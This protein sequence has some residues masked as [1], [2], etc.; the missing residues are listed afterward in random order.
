MSRQITATLGFSLVVAGLPALALALEW[1]AL[2]ADALPVPMWAL[3]CGGAALVFA[4]SS[5][6]LPE[7]FPRPRGFLCALSVSALAA[8]FDWIA[9][10]HLQGGW[11]FMLESLLNSLALKQNAVH[12]VAVLFAVLLTLL[13]MFSWA[14]WFRNLAQKEG[15]PPKTPGRRGKARESVE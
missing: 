6:L 8:I 7:S 13:A 5:I 9:F 3:G 15:T 2:P 10:G 12:N 11:H 4:G 1:L 14:Q